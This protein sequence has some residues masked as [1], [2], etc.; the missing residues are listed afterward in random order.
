MNREEL[1]KILD[2]E[3]KKYNE[4]INKERKSEKKN[5]I[6]LP[7]KIL[8]MDLS[9]QELMLFLSILSR[10]NNETGYTF[11]GDE[12]L[13]EDIGKSTKTVQRIL[14]S[15]EKKK[16]IRREGLGPKSKRYII[17][18]YYQGQK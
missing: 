18:T 6:V 13:S 17:L 4:F 16:L 1:E 5:F 3:S 11:V 14:K 8:N 7:K 10:V 15:L 9:S 12:K 2:E